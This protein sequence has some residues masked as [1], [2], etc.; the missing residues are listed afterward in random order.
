MRRRQTRRSA[1]RPTSDVAVRAAHY[2]PSGRLAVSFCFNAPR[3]VAFLGPLVA[4]SLITRFGGYGD[5]ATIVSSI[6]VLGL[7]AVPFLPETNGKP[8]PE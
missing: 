6:Y 3:F 8:L 2:T 1:S 5:A 4:G 7:V